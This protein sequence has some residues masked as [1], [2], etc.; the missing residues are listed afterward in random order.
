MADY[1]AGTFIHPSYWPH[2][3]PDLNGK[4][5]AIIGT[6]ATGVQLTT[7]V[8][9]VVSQLTV[10]QRTPCTA[11]PMRQV[12]YGL[13]NQTDQPNAPKAELFQGRTKSFGGFDFNF[14]PRATF[15]DTPSER[16]ATYESLWAEGDFKY[17]L[18]TYHDMLFVKEANDAAY[19]FWCDKTRA[20]LHDAKIAEKLAPIKPQ[21]AFGCKR[22]PLELGYFETFNEPHVS[23]VDVNATP[24]EEITESGIRTSEKEMQFDYIICATGYDAVTGGFAQIGIKGIEGYTL[25]KHWADGAKTYL[26]MC[27][28]GF[29]NMFFTYGPQAPTTL[30]NGPTCAELQGDWIV[31]VIN[32]MKEKKMK[33]ISAR[34][35][36]EAMWK[37]QVWGAANSTLLPSTRS[38]SY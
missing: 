28:A 4:K 2:D 34:G 27:V 12:D 30:C 24:I 13:V 19:D 11:L 26:G 22:I 29:P 17:W 5:V 10:F 35:E 23:L 14:L 36:S 33:K 21:Y 37:E 15:D 32:Y 25:K 31:E 1:F 16:L 8:S 18:A 38:V 9:K 3:E 7:T 6:G 20:K